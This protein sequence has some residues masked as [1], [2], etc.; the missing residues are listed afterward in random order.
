MAGEAA[1][2]YNDTSQNQPKMQ[3]QQAPPNYG[4][5]YNSGPPPQP[6]MNGDGKQTFDQT[7][8]IDKPKYND[9]WA[10]ILVGASPSCPFPSSM[11]ARSEGTR[12]DKTLH[13][14]HPHFPRL[15]RHKWYLSRRL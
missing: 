15:R 4:Q 9:L 14:V 6:Q 8:K 7:F 10:G 2:Y 11:A 13:A 3:Y 12:I 5:N 1:S